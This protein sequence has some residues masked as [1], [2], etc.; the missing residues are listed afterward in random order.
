MFQ[1]RLGLLEAH[2][3]VFRVCVQGLESLDTQGSSVEHDFKQ[4]IC[5]KIRNQSNKNYI[6]A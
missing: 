1:K 3:R 5:A 2:G 6:F 4:I